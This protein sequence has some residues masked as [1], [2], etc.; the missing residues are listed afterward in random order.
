[1]PVNVVVAGILHDT[2]EDTGV[3]VKDLER[4]F[5]K[6]IA[7]FVD[8]VS[9]LGEVR[10]RG[11][12]VRVQSLQKLFVATSKDIRVII[13]KLMDR[14]HNMRTLASV[15]KQKQKRIAKETQRV[16]ARSPTGSVW[17]MCGLSWRTSRLSTCSR[18]CTRPW[19]KISPR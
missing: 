8:S 17:E 1:M 12:D 19:K 15:P 4:E 6:E 2:I 11:L 3:T 14:L 13:I 7:F 18:S 16:Y 5:G 9:H 10:Y